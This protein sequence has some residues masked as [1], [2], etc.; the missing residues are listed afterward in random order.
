MF[1]VVTLSTMLVI[2]PFVIMIGYVIVNG[3]GAIDADFFTGEW[4]T[5]QGNGR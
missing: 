1:V 4:V 5:C 2:A 3:L